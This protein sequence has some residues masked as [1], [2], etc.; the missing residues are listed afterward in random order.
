MY[1]VF[2][3]LWML[4]RHYFYFRGGGNSVSSLRPRH[5]VEFMAWAVESEKLGLNANKVCAFLN[6]NFLTYKMEMKIGPN[7]KGCW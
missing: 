2:A 6:F 4:N 7:S 1:L 5:T 3:P